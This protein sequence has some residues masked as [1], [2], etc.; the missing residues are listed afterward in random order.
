[1]HDLIV[2]GGGPAGL[3]A[4]LYALRAGKSVMLLEKNAFGGQIAFS[5][6]VENYPGSESMTGSDFA[7][8]LFSQ[9]INLGVDF[10]IAMVTGI[11]DKGDHKQVYTEDGDIHQAR[12]V[13]IAVGAK[14]RKLGVP[15]ENELAS[16]GI[17]YCAVCDGDFYRGKKVAMVGGG[18]TALQEAIFLSDICEQVTIIQ[19][20]DDF[21][22]EARLVQALRRRG[23]VDYIFGAQVASVHGNQDGLSHVKVRKTVSG[24]ELELPLDG[25]FVAIGLEP[26]NEPF[27]E[28]VKLNEYGYID[29][30][31]NCLTA[32]PGVF[33]AG[34]CRS[35][36]I[37]QL[38]TATADGTVAALAALRYLA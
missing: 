12:S 6:K 23:N 31:E 8:R 14:H 33:V 1:M 9:V 26:E 24:E 34:D 27:S 18:N 3:T 28:L 5:P 4:A 7:D 30:D 20:L 36:H 19:N 29:A 13:I 25:L 16:R 11:E 35:K 22:G 38:T 32:T 17:C 37:R 21:T 10:D 2:I 15:G